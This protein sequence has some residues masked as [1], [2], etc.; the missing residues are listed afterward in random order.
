MALRALVAEPAG[1]RDQCVRPGLPQKVGIDA[2][3]QEDAGRRPARN[4]TCGPQQLTPTEQDFELAWWPMNEAFDA[5]T[6]GRFL[7]PAGPLALLLAE[8]AAQ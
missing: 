1:E 8:R 4:L 7:L 2:A 3:A 5:V 6:Q